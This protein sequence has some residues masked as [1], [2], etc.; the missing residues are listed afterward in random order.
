MDRKIAVMASTRPSAEVVFQVPENPK[1]FGKL[2]KIFSLYLDLD[3]IVWAC[4][5]HYCNFS[6][7][8]RRHLIALDE[9][10]RMTSSLPRKIEVTTRN[11]QNIET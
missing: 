8:L 9:S 4:R 10:C 2:V 5:A 6:G 3:P 11:G 1:I 7:R